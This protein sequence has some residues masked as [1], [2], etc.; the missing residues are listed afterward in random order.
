M[1]I[2]RYGRKIGLVEYRIDF[3]NHKIRTQVL[4]SQLET[5]SLKA[6]VVGGEPDHQKHKR[7]S[8]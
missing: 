1:G 3:M 2:S 6:D 7:D 8:C 4:R 5:W